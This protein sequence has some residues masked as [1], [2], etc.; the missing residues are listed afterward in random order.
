MYNRNQSILE[1]IPKLKKR[2]RCFIL[3]GGPSLVNLDFSLL[4]D[5]FTIGVNRSFEKFPTDILYCMDYDF[6]ERITGPQK[7]MDVYAKDSVFDKFVNFKGIK[8]FLA[9]CDEKIKYDYNVFVIN[10]VYK[11]ELNTITSDI[12]DSIYGGYNSG[13]GA[14][15]LAI[16]LEYTDVVLLGFDLK[17][18]ENSTHYHTGY[19]NQDLTNYCNNIS[20]WHKEWFEWAPKFLEKGIN[21][22]TC[23]LNSKEETD[24]TCFP[25]KYL[26]EML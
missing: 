10:R 11:N 5:K 18:K 2:N 12:K 21:I 24:L 16:Y 7:Q 22:T 25:V 26:K 6:Y 8:V 19:P 14:L 15:M 1:A 23:V 4:A 13:F 20:L 9:V 3:G 17:V